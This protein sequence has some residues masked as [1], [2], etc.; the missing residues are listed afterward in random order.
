[1]FDRQKH[2][3]MILTVADIVKVMGLLSVIWMNMI[4]KIA[5]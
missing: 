1:M 5:S 4:L 2:H 3:D